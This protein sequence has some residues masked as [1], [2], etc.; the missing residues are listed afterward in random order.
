MSAALVTLVPPEVVTVTSTV[1][2]LAGA[3][4]VIV[5]ELSTAKVEAAVVPKFRAVAPVKFVP[6]IVSK[7]P[8]GPDVGL[9]PATVGAGGSV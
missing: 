6:V 3:M 4:A 1:P 2:V 7:L 8:L 5:V 9:T